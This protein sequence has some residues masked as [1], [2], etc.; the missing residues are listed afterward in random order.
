MPRWIA[1]PPNMKKR[2]SKWHVKSWKRVATAKSQIELVVDD[3][4]RLHSCYDGNRPA[5]LEGQA[6][7]AADALAHL[8]T[9]FYVLLHANWPAR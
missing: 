3:A 9:D 7:A 1:M 2:V 8:K 6:L 4:I 5:S